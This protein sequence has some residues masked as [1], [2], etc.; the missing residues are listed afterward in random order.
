MFTEAFW[1]K[2]LLVACGI[3]ALQGVWSAFTA[4][5]DPFGLWNEYVASTFGKQDNL[6]SEAMKVK[7]FMHGPLGGTL[8]GYFVMAFF[9]VFHGFPKRMR[10][11]YHAVAAGL[12]AWFLVDSAACCIHG[13]YFNVAMVN[14]PALLILG[15]PLAMLRKAFYAAT[16]S[17]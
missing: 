16:S 17:S 6:S 9:L 10:W 13:A 7:A 1:R 11:T 15:I 12:L 14:I 5:P 4:S 3:F 2:W 8:A